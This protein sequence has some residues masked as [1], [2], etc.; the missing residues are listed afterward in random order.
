MNDL[1][2]VAGLEDLQV[3][4][5]VQFG[6]LLEV[7]FD[8]LVDVL[9]EQIYVAVGYHF[10]AILGV[11]N[12]LQEQNEQQVDVLELAPGTLQADQLQELYHPVPEADV[13]VGD[14]EGQRHGVQ[15][16]VHL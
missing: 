12:E 6:H 10:L 1:G 13:P 11:Y 3:V 2:A 4:Q 7:I 14:A 15:V 9:A 8:E 16:D 5:L